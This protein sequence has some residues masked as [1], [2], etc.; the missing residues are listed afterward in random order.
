MIDE[1][2]ICGDL[3]DEYVEAWSNLG[4]YIK[5]YRKQLLINDKQTFFQLLKWLMKNFQKC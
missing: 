2:I 4:I 3:F 5:K 1:L